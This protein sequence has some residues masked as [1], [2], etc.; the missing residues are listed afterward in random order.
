[1]GTI[2]G[3]RCACIEERLQPVCAKRVR[4]RSD[5]HAAQPAVWCDEILHP[6]AAA[7]IADAG[8]AYER[9]GNRQCGVSR[10][11]RRTARQAPVVSHRFQR[12]PDQSGIQEPDFRTRSDRRPAAG[13]SLRPSALGRI[14]PQGRLR[15]VD[16]ADRSQQQVPSQFPGAK[17]EQ[18]LELRHRTECAGTPASAAVQMPL[19]RTHPDP[20]LQ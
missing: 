6:V 19:W 12:Q 11:T 13:R 4:R 9:S 17:S 18:R 7:R 8:P 2:H 10:R 3:N 1:M 20:H 14:L 16:R 5:R 15:D